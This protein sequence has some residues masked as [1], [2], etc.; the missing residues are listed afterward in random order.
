MK[1]LILLIAAAA[2][3]ALAGCSSLRGPSAD[4]LA[5]AQDAQCRSYGSTPGSAAYVN[6]RTQLAGQYAEAEQR[7]RIAIADGIAAHPVE[8]HPLPVKPTINCTTNTYG[9]QTVY[10]SCQ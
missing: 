2:A 9:S 6:C 10:T 7:R 8:F 3:L 1:P 4:Q 5:A